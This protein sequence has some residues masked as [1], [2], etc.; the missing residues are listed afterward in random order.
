MESDQDSSLRSTLGS[1]S[2]AS[3]DSDSEWRLSLPPSR[4]H[5]LPVE[6]LSE[7]FLLALENDEERPGSEPEHLMLVCRRWRAIM[8]LTPGICCGLDISDSITMEVVEESIRG[9]KWLLDVDITMDSGTVG[10]FFNADYFYACFMAAAEVAPRWRSLRILRFPLPKEHKAVQ[11]VQPLE[12]LESFSLPLTH[13]LGNSFEPLLTAIATTSTTYLT[14]M[15]LGDPDVILH[16][17]Q[18]AC[19][20]VF[21]S[22]ETLKIWQSKRPR[23]EA[24]VD[25]LPHLQ[26]LKYL[27]T[28]H[29][30]FPIYSPD[31]SLPLVQTL[32]TLDLTSVSI[33]WMAGRD[34][35][36]LK[37]CIIKFPHHA[38]TIALQPVTMPSCTY[39][40]Y[41]SNDLRPLVCFRHLPLA[42]FHVRCRQWS[43]WRGNPQLVALCP[44]FTTQSMTFLRLHI[45]CSEWLLVEMLKLVPA[46]TTL[47]LELASPRVLSEA[48]FLAF[49]A[50]ESNAVSPRE[51][52]GLPGQTRPRLC[53]LLQKLHLRFERWLRGPEKSVLIPVLSDVVSSYQP[54]NPLQHHIAFTAGYRT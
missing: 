30:H 10:N 20:H 4:D 39:L 26:R 48:F 2:D 29:L 46:L 37:T 38:D 5:L 40:E 16:F 54:E 9:R 42:F 32:Q 18:P 15:V 43:V 22:L 44:M 49:V 27:R 24:P 14:E 47:K 3:W 45:Q 31:A 8:L 19:L 21:H 34:F 11:I 23:M 52:V 17:A 12:R 41:D 51:I 6:I 50:T 35:P 7:I 36:A 53:P 13:S 28:H 33:Q 1:S 25:I